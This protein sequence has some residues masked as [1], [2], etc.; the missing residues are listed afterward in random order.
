M[1]QTVRMFPY[2]FIYRGRMAGSLYK[3]YYSQRKANPYGVKLPEGMQLM[4]EFPQPIFT[5]TD[6]SE[7]DEPIDP[8][9]MKDLKRSDITVPQGIYTFMR[10]YALKRGIDIIDTKLELGLHD[11]RRTLADEWGTPDS[12]RFVDATSIMRGEEPRWLDK[13]FLRDEA[14]MIWKQEG[15]GKFPLVFSSQAIQETV[16]RYHEVVERL[17]SQSLSVLQD[18]LGLT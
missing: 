5:P 1:V 7:T 15:R 4:D 3:D 9:T 18:S 6:K 2:E 11:G 10:S 13:Q 14:E 17:T 12:S 8:K 16:G